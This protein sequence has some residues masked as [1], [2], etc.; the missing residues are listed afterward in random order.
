M[1]QANVAAGSATEVFRALFVFTVQSTPA[2][3]IFVALYTPT[4]GLRRCVYSANF[5]QDEGAELHIEEDDDPSIFPELPL[6]T[7]PQNR[8]IATG[9]LINTPD[10]E[11]RERPYKRAWTHDDALTEIQAQTCR[12]FDPAL[13]EP[14]MAAVEAYSSR[15]GH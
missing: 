14:F 7:G 9:A 6:N 15:A 2:D 3:A 13:V 8:A 1:A 5:V 12:Q 11:L 10:L 4:T